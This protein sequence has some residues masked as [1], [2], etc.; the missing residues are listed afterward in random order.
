M[1]TGGRSLAIL[2]LTLVTGS[3]PGAAPAAQNDA[4]R[5]IEISAERF[6]FWP[7]QI[8]INE[9]EQVEFRVTS[10][11]TMHGFRIVG[12]GVSLLVP[13][14]GKGYASARFTGTRPGRYTFECARMCGAGH[15][16]MRGELIVRPSAQPQ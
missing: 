13:K 3:A 2:L 7:S 4:V 14:R 9:G 11:D 6:E 10:D 5:V 15:H 1:T 16:F 8:V 12:G